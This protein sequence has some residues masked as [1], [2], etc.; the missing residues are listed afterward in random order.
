MHDEIYKL[1]EKQ[2][3]NALTFINNI[4]MSI[5]DRPLQANHLLNIL[6][7]AII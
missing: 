4:I 7:L 1:E 3:I 6:Y 5:S 2:N